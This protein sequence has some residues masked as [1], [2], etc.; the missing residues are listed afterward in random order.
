MWLAVI[1]VQRTL[2]RFTRTFVAVVVGNN[3]GQEDDIKGKSSAAIN[4]PLL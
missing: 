1:N 2:V 4:F 3:L